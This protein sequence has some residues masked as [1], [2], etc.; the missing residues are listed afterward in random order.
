M[1][2]C[3]YNPEAT[4]HDESCIYPENAYDYDGMP[5]DFRADYLGLWTFQADW[6]MA[7]YILEG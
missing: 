1:S 5:S 6:F 3:N 4:I 7:V 2:A